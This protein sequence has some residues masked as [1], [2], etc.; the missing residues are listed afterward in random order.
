[1]GTKR[2]KLNMRYLRDKKIAYKRFEYLAK[3]VK[4]KKI[5]DVGCQDANILNFLKKPVDYTGINKFENKEL[6]KRGVKF[7]VI[8]VCKTKMPFSAR[9]FDTAIMGEIIEHLENPL[10][11]LKEANR[12]LKNGGILI[13]STPNTYNIQN[14]IYSSVSEPKKGDHL[15]AFREEELANLL[16]AA[17]FKR[18]KIEKICS[19]IPL[20]QVNLPDNRIFKIFATSYLFRGKKG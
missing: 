15:Y 14:F 13:G 18:I 12:V 19:R 17:G 1:M 5:L 8:D 9:K 10:F 6:R 7:V 4:G 3:H 2:T 16:R 11:A 20:T